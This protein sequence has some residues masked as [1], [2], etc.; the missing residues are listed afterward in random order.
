M[1]KVISI[2]LAV[3]TLMGLM[4][5]VFAGA[6]GNIRYVN[7]EDGKR[8]NVRETANGKIAYRIECGTQVEI[9]PTVAAPAGWAYVRVDGHTN[10]GF[11]MTKFLVSSKPGENE[12]T[13]RS[14]HFVP[15][16]PYTVKAKALNSRTEQ[17][18][19][20]RV[21]PNKTSRA[22][23][24]LAAGDTLQVIARG[25]TWSRVVDPTTGETGYVANAYMVMQ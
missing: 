15:V 8:L 6:E 21:S 19:G 13:E 14:D 4:I 5:P 16:T 1:K 20:L 10:G 24:R 17:S 22:I 11:V 18:V 25:N 2:M 12:I 7:C 9:M 3:M 23:R